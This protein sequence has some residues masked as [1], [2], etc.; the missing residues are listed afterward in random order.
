[1]IYATAQEMQKDQSVSAILI[2]VKSAGLSGPIQGMRRTDAYGATPKDMPTEEVNV[3]GAGK[4]QVVS[5]GAMIT[6]A[7]AYHRSK[8]ADGGYSIYDVHVVARSAPSWKD[9]LKKFEAWRPGKW[10]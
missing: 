9:D 7:L 1:M 6:A 3:P 8:V 5:L 4:L 10:A 2:F